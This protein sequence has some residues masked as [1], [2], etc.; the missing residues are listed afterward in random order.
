MIQYLGENEIVFCGSL[1]VLLAGFF[2]F[3]QL[4]LKQ[5]TNEKDKNQDN[6]EKILSFVI[7]I[8]FMVEGIVFL[9]PVD[10]FITSVICTIFGTALLVGSA[11]RYYIRKKSI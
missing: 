4:I 3:G 9:I 7:A 5:K 2:E 11:Y 8:C 10:N 6:R 1:F